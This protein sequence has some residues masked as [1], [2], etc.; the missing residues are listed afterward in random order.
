MK[1]SKIILEVTEATSLLKFAHLFVK[2]SDTLSPLKTNPFTPELTI[3]IPY[4][5]LIKL[6]DDRPVSHKKE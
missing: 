1:I 4:L 5:Y 2:L 3:T 6:A